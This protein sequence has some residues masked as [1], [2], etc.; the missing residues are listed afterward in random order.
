MSRNAHACIVFKLNVFTVKRKDTRISGKDWIFIVRK[1]LILPVMYNVKVEIIGN[2]TY[3]PIKL[4][5][6]YINESGKSAPLPYK[7]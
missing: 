1:D 3:S 6:C 5:H 7:H 4:S 2:M